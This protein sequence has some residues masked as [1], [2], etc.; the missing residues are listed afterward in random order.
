MMAL[1]S[2]VWAVALLELTGQAP[3]SQLENPLLTRQREKQ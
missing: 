1:S 2:L 3:N